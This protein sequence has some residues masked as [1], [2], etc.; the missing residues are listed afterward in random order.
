MPTSRVE[1]AWAVPVKIKQFG[2]HL[3]AYTSLQPVLNTLQLCNRFG[4]GPEAAITKLPTELVQ[5]IQK[6]MLKEKQEELIP[7]WTRDFRCWQSLCAPIDHLSDSDIL[8]LYNELRDEFEVAECP[9]GGCFSP[10]KVT[11]VSESV[12]DLVADVVEE[13]E[14]LCWGGEHR[15]RIEAWHER[16]GSPTEVSR[17][18]FDEFSNVLTKHFGLEAWISHVQESRQ[19]A[20]VDENVTHTTKSYLVLPQAASFQHDFELHTIETGHWEDRRVPTE[21]GFAT[22]LSLPPP[23]SPKDTERF[24]RALKALNIAACSTQ[25]ASDSLQVNDRVSGAIESDDAEDAPLAAEVKP[26]LTLFIRNDNKE[27]W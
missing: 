22:E 20:W 24:I 15:S 6:Y 18:R 27:E 1:V 17:G 4:R 26:K 12:R 11:T 7:A 2:P 21:A 23:L 10:E 16:V 9:C 5:H 19:V 13:P 8:E 14:E 3:E 25:K